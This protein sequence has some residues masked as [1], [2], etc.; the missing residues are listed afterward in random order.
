VDPTAG[1][2]VAATKRSAYARSRTF[3]FG[4]WMLAGAV[5]LIVWH[6]IQDSLIAKREN[7]RTVEGTV[8]EHRSTETSGTSRVKLAR[9]GTQTI[10]GSRK[11]RTVLRIRKRD[12]AIAEFTASE[13]FRTPKEGWEN[14][15]IRVQ[16]DSLGYLYEIVVAGEV[17]RDVETT[18]RYRKIDNKSNTGLWIFLLLTG[19]P[20]TI[21]GYLL[22][23]R[24]KAGPPPLPR[25]P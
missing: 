24:A 19:L 6:G 21:V 15:P 4:V 2:P 16:H 9:G 14:Q 17:I 22:S 11:L 23:L 20:F 13:W 12:G 8:V 3:R 1:H 7:L 18:W 5:A 25:S 10:Q